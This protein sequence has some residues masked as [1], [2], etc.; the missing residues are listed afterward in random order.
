MLLDVLTE[1]TLDADRKGESSFSF[2][3]QLKN[4]KL[5]KST[6][7]INKTFAFNKRCVYRC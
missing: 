4:E 1:L 7:L 5:L 3:E 6:E 2:V